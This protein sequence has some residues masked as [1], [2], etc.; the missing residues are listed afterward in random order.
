MTVSENEL[1]DAICEWEDACGGKYTVH[2][3]KFKGHDYISLDITG[4][5]E[6]LADDVFDL[7]SRDPLIARYSCDFAKQ[8]LT[9]VLETHRRKVPNAPLVAP[10]GPVSG[11]AESTDQLALQ[12]ELDAVRPHALTET[13]EDLVMVCKCVLAVRRSIS[14]LNKI[15]DSVKFDYTSTPGLFRITARGMAKVEP[16]LFAAFKRLRADFDAEVMLILSP[17]SEQC[18]QISLKKAKAL[19]NV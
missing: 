9:F 18:V 19:V 11:N 5:D 7:V 6:V 8:A 15:S 12:K 10:T 14:M 16:K 1:V 2:K 4:V 3:E 13:E 17:K